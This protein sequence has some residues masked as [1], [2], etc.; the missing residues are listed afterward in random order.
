MLY[1]VLL[2]DFI[3]DG[4]SAVYY[5]KINS[6]GSVQCLLLDDLGDELA[7]R[8]ETDGSHRW[9]NDTVA[10]SSFPALPS[11]VAFIDLSQGLQ[12]ALFNS[13]LLGLN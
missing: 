11:G 6:F 3:N 8:W 2:N 7:W 4:M 1:A 12:L 5:H 9:R 10:Q 13:D